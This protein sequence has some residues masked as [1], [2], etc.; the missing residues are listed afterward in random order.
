M[1]ILSAQQTREADAHTIR[2]EPILSIDLME[3]AANQ[4]FHAIQR[5]A[6]QKKQICVFC[7]PGNNGGDGLALARKLAEANYPVHIYILKGRS[8]FSEDAAINLNRLPSL[9][10]LNLDYLTDNNPLPDILPD[11]LIIDALFGSGL[12]RTLEGFPATLV[13]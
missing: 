4:L 9:P 12:N 3:R 11:S 8:G 2:E 1:K 6:L 13:N 7:G 5:M 10:W